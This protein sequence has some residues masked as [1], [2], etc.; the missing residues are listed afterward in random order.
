MGYLQSAPYIY[1]QMRVGGLVQKWG[2]EDWISVFAHMENQGYTWDPTT[3][4]L[5][6]R[7][8]IATLQTQTPWC[9]AKTSPEKQCGL[10]H[11]IIFGNWR[12]ITPRCMHC[13]KVCVTLES[14]DDTIKCEALQR[15]MDY[16][17]KCGMEMRDYTPKFWGAYWYTNSLEEGRE[18]YTEVKEALRKHVSDYAAEHCILKRSCTEFEMVKGPSPYWHITDDE[19][20]F[21]EYI[22]AFI[23]TYDSNAEQA[24]MVK[25]HCHL[26]WVLWAHMNNDMSYLKYNDGKKL[27]PGY[28]TYHEGNLDDIKHDIALAHTQAKHGIDP[29]K[30]DKF[31]ALADQFCEDEGIDKMSFLATGLGAQHTPIKMG[32]STQLDVA[33]EQLD[34]VPDEVKGEHDELT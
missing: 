16:P 10:D 5:N 19:Y 9:H 25:R 18:R 14:F 31:L 12:I 34:T 26:K 24:E 22:E 30:T 2:Q 13:W 27:F 20:R 4:K 32:R 3:L 1:N 28:V 15:R 6:Q 29:N 8:T 7:G 11:N 21:L 33:K 23:D 17:S